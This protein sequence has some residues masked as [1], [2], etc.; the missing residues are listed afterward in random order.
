MP[1]KEI[2]YQQHQNTEEWAIIANLLAELKNNQ[3]IEL[4]TAPEYV[5][6]YL[7]ERLRNKGEGQELQKKVKELEIKIIS[8][9]ETNQILRKDLGYWQDKQLEKELQSNKETIKKLQT[10]RQQLIEKYSKLEIEFSISGQRE[11]G[12]KIFSWI[13]TTSSFGCKISAGCK[14]SFFTTTSDFTTRLFFTTWGDFTTSKLFTISS[15]FFTTCFF[16]K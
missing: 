4:K 13:F 12:C 6:G 9:Q 5:V 11:Q 10:E 8:L 16:C 7:V 2:P 3:D 1:I 14:F 15:P